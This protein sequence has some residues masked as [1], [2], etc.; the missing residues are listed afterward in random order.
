MKRCHPQPADAVAFEA[1]ILLNAFEEPLDGLTL[2]VQVLPG[3]AVAWNPGD[4]TGILVWV[5]PDFRITISYYPDERV[6]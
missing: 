2:G 3:L 1:A 6:L 4:A 5:L